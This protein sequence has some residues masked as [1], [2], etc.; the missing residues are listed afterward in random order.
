MGRD[1]PVAAL[2]ALV[3]PFL[4]TSSSRSEAARTG[5]NASQSSRGFHRVMAW[6]SEPYLLPGLAVLLSSAWAHLPFDVEAPGN[7]IYP[8]TLSGNWD[9]TYAMQ[10]A[11]FWA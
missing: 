8:A 5:G 7:T 4:P 11:T 2:T 9:S 10:A 3:L 1:L 6:L